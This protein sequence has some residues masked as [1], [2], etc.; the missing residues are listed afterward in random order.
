MKWHPSGEGWITHM[1][2]PYAHA[3]HAHPAHW[4]GEH[5]M[6]LA[7]LLAGLI[8]LLIVGLAALFNPEIKP[9]ML[10]PFDYRTVYPYYGATY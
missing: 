2:R 5:P 9:D 4:L 1:H 7:L 3:I 6:M 8:T 10:R